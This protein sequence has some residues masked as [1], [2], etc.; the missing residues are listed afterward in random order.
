MPVITFVESNGTRHDLEANPGDSV[1]QVATYNDVPGIVAE[2]GGAAACATCRVQVDK[3]WES[4][5]PPAGPLEMSTI[6]A[7]DEE[8]GLSGQRLS[9]QIACSDDLDGLVVHVPASQY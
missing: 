4:M 3:V 8:E 1:M 6:E 7:F 5:V 2:C 9:C